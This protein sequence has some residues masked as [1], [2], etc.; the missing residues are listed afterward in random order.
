[1][2]QDAIRIRQLS[3]I[4]KTHPFSPPVKALD[5]LDLTVEK[6]EI[7][8][9][10]G[11]NGA[12]KTTTIRLLLN[13]IR[14]SEGDCKVFDLDVQRD[15]V[16]IRSFI[17]NLPSELSL[18]E[19]MTGE[20]IL[21]Y[22]ARLRPGTDIN[23]AFELAERFQLD[24][25]IPVGR[26]S[27][28]NKRKVG[29][30]QALMHRPQLVIMDEPTSGLDPLMRQVFA[31]VL[32]ALRDQGRTIFLSSHVLS[33]VQ[34]VCDRVAILR[35]GQLQTV[36][37]IHDAMETRSIHVTTPGPFDIAALEQV[38]GVRKVTQTTHGY[39]ISISGSMEM[40]FRFLADYPIHDFRTEELSLEDRFAEYYKESPKV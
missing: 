29:I 34:S 28:G 13:L 6:G 32:L 18:W 22:L 39:R 27:T 25:S 36:Q 37:T 24:L 21:R 15:S 3:K 23:Y 11:P 33:E 5:K 30:V 35:A 20:Q 26:Y 17:G 7:F 10:L 2:T 8:G 31:E 38:T 9:Y 16:A 4:Y 19:H 40:L 1:M 12:G 14:P